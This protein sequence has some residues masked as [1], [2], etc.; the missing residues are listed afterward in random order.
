[1]KYKSP[2]DLDFDDIFAEESPQDLKYDTYMFLKDALGIDSVFIN[3]SVWSKFSKEQMDVYI[4][5]VF[6]HYREN[7]F[8]Y[9]NLSHNQRLIELE[10]LKNFRASVLDNKI[11]KQTMHGLSLAWHY[12]P[13]AW[14]V[15]CG[16]LKTPM[17]AFTDDTMF[18]NVIRKRIQTGSYISDGG[19][20]KM[21]KMYTG[22]QGV[23]NFRP[24]AARSIYDSYAGDGTVWDMSCGYGGR[25]LGAIA[26]ER[27]HTYLGTDP[28]VPTYNGLVAIKND[29]GNK[30]I[31]LLNQCSET[32]TF[33][34]KTVDLCF[35]SPPYFNCE[36]YAN[37]TT[38][39]YIRY[40]AK[41]AWM[42]NFLGATVESCFKC[43]KDTGYLIININNVKSY[44]ELLEDF[45]A[46]VPQ[47][48]FKLVDTLQYS[49]SSIH[50]AGFKYEPVFVFKKN[51]HA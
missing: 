41:N 5:A 9:Y 27:V 31:V 23:S 38:Q 7:G 22:V 42:H 29:F 51:K 13:H 21:L 20:R 12:F 16:T 3:K 32:T 50:K 18:K 39:S 37:D 45:L 48:G 10:K 6:A 1:M 30:N 14:E 8:P 35:T 19:M 40:P 47:K 25:L 15:Q 33:P 28:C 44:P 43:L 24:T 36:K 26:S 17:Q 2:I 11:I 49:L 4:D 34:A 46:L